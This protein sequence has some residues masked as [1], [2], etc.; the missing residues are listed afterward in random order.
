MSDE[1][2]TGTSGSSLVH[3]TTSSNHLKL[4]DKKTNEKLN[5]VT[6]AVP[7]SILCDAMTH[8]ASRLCHLSAQF[9]YSDHRAPHSCAL[10]F[11][12]LWAWRRGQ[13]QCLYHHQHCC[14]WCRRYNCC[15]CWLVCHL[16]S[17][18]GTMSSIHYA[19]IYQSHKKCCF[20]VGFFM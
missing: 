11:N 10:L 16:R 12:I 13:C 18:W 1:G 20:I 4:N 19:Q 8:I 15:C 5:C 17:S 3:C 14:C 6:T 7:L 2:N 9:F